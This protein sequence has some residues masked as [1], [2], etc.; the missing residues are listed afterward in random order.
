MRIKQNQLAV[1][2]TY[3]LEFLQIKIFL[4][5]LKIVLIN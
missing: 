3:L 1:V 5:Q 4:I 2:K